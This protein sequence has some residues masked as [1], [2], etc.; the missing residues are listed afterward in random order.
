MLDGTCILGDPRIWAGAWA[1][2]WALCALLEAGA[3]ALAV[4]LHVMLEDRRQNPVRGVDKRHYHGFHTVVKLLPARGLVR[5]HIAMRHRVTNGFPKFPG[6]EL[7]HTEH[8][9]RRGF[10]N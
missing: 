4:A 7:I 6:D 8:L 10:Q 1:R 3:R 2:A 9:N 5:L